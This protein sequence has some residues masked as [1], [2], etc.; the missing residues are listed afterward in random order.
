MH[1]ESWQLGGRHVYI[2]LAPPG[3]CIVFKYQ[4][5][6]INNTPENP[7]AKYETS[8]V[9]GAGGSEGRGEEGGHPEGGA[10]VHRDV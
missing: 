7:T 4:L 10:R 6:S 3:N 1:K 5:F 2:E 8:V 9:G